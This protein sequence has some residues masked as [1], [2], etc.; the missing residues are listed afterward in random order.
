VAK[1]KAILESGNIRWSKKV[2]L[3]EIGVV[4]VGVTELFW[5]QWAKHRSKYSSL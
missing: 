5:A 4:K 3:V 1:S 2:M